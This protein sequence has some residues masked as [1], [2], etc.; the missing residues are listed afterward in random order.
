MIPTLLEGD[1][2]VVNKFIYGTRV[3]FSDV[4]VFSIREPKRGEI[5]VFEYPNDRRVHYIKR[6]IGLPGDEI[7]IKDKKLYVN[8]KIYEVEGAHHI[9]SMIYP[10]IAGTRDNFGA[11]TVPPDSYFMMGDNRDNSSDSRSWGYVRRSELV[12]NGVLI[13]WSWGT[14]SGGIVERIKNVRWNRLGDILLNSSK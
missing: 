10:S 11:V 1:R 9:D 3:P 13:Y 5:V 14:T 8:G 12:G 7:E 6:L 2:V 4:K